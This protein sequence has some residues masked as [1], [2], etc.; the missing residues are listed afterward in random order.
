MRLALRGWCFK[1]RATL[2][3][4]RDHRWVTTHPQ[5]PPPTTNPGRSVGKIAAV[6]TAGVVVLAVITSGVIL[7]WSLATRGLNGSSLVTARLD[8]VKIGLAALGGAAAL[9]ALYLN[10]RRQRTTDA[11]LLLQQTVAAATEADAA[12]RRITELYAK[13]ADQLGSDKAAVRLAGLY[14]LERLAQDNQH[15]RQTIVRR[16]VVNVLCAYLRMP[17]VLPGDPPADDAEDKLIDVYRERG[18]EREVRL[19]AQRILTDHLRITTSD[20]IDQPGSAVPETYWPDLT[21]DLTGATLIDFDFTGCRAAAVTF[22]QAKFVGTARFDGAQFNGAARFENV[23]FEH[24]VP[25]EVAQF[26]SKPHVAEGQ[27]AESDE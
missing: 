5:L 2:G 14:A 26:I 27:P 7:L 24:T 6:I 25:P 12:A 1:A 9:V 16:T 22:T 23:R 8:A 20:K 4:D 3:C 21:I 11:T 15:E 13:A 18:Q 10:W 17:Y 19:A